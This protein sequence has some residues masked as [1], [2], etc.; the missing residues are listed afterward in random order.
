MRDIKL[1]EIKDVL[2]K[3]KTHFKDLDV[4]Q[5]VIELDDALHR[6]L[7]EDIVSDMVIPAYRKSTVDGY[8]MKL[9]DHKVTRRLISEHDILNVDDLKCGQD[10]VY[11]PTGGKVPEDAEV[12]VKIEETTKKNNMVTFNSYNHCENIIEIGADMKKGDLL[13]ASGHRITS[14]DIG[15]LGLLGYHQVKVLRK[16]TLAIISTGDELVPVASSLKLGQ[17]RDINT[18][19]LKSMAVSYGMD[20]EFSTL[21]IDTK[22]ALK[23]AICKAAEATDITIVSGGSS[24]GVKDYTFDILNEIGIILSDGMALKP[25]KP[26]IIS[27][28]KGK[29]LIGLPGHPVS[30]LMVFKILMRELLKVYKIEVKEDVAI[31]AIA[32]RD[33]KP[34]RGRDTYQMLHFS[35]DKGQKYAH[36]TSGKSGMMTLLTKSEGYTIIDKNTMIH[37]G[38]LITCYLF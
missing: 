3:M 7:A 2:Q 6:C 36:P 29:P 17:T 28:Y 1:N 5:E 33:V 37:K 15:V 26:T 32:S 21:V 38:D 31:K 4:G 34:A 19:T 23:D 10:C 22:S 18:H 30:A 13:Y 9:T 16:P 8:A 35:N 12:M 11:V 20:V 24:M 14:F 27:D 25:G